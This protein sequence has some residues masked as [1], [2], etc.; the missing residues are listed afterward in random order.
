MKIHEIQMTTYDNDENMDALVFR[1][2][3]MLEPHLHSYGKID[4][5]SFVG[6]EL[7]N[8]GEN[9]VF[10]LIDGSNPVA[11][12]SLAAFPYDPIYFYV[13]STWINPRYRGKGFMKKLYSFFIEKGYKLITDITQTPDSKNLWNS[14][15]GKY[16]LAL[17][18]DG[19][20]IQSINNQDDFNKAYQN[21]E[22]FNG[23]R[24]TVKR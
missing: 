10:F 2:Y 14:F 8:K 23:A 22:N 6:N 5:L 19:K 7:P 12:Y 20:E 11:F 4:N 21:D 3:S 16:Q 13:K 9:S 24:I 1:R 15:L 18:K 17:Y